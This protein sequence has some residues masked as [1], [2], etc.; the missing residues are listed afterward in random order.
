MSKT[1][2]D[3]EGLVYDMLSTNTG[4]HFMDSGGDNGRHWQRNQGWWT[5]TTA[6]VDWT[7]GNR[8]ARF[9]SRDS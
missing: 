2:T 4:V 7:A 5:G 8:T 6:V 3:L 9:T 1:T